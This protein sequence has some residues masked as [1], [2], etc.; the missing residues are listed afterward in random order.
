M[1]L[2]YREKNY[3]LDIPYF[4]KFTCGQGDMK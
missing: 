3:F 4:Y 1:T 2:I